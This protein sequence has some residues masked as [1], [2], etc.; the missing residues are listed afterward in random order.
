MFFSQYIVVNKGPLNKVWLAAHMQKKLTKNFV[1]EIDIVDNVKTLLDPSTPLALRLSGQLLL[2]LV[3]IYSRKARYLQEDCSS[4][5][6]NIKVVFR[7]A[8]VI[9][10]PEDAHGGASAITLMENYDDLDLEIEDI[11]LEDIEKLKAN[12]ARAS[13][14]TQESRLSQRRKSKGGE[15]DSDIEQARNA[16]SKEIDFDINIGGEG[17]ELLNFDDLDPNEPNNLD[18]SSML[19]FDAADI[20]TV[21]DQT[22]GGDE[23]NIPPENEKEDDEMDMGLPPVVDENTAQAEEPTPKAKAAEKKKRVRKRARATLDAVVEMTSKQIKQQLKDTTNIKTKREIAESIVNPKRAR[24]S[25]SQKTPFTIY[26]ADS[27]APALVNRIMGKI[28]ESVSKKARVSKEIGEEKG[29]AAGDEEDHKEDLAGPE[30]KEDEFQFEFDVGMDQSLM[31]DTT[32]D[33]GIDTS[34]EM[35]NEALDNKHGDTTQHGDPTQES[36]IEESEV[37]KADRLIKMYH[38]LKNKMADRKEI[39]FHE[40]CGPASRKAAAGIFHELLVLKTRTM[41]EVNQEEPYGDIEITKTKQFDKG[42]TPTPVE[43]N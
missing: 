13:D 43:A 41:I 17:E 16:E 6:A 28:Q 25:S 5:M 27:L 30:G 38:F 23:E 2:G 20:S 22:L 32:M 21:H 19:D 12:V 8:A 3:N 36:G 4:A 37:T 7:P 9:D 42:L 18:A 14:I 40:M 35:Q 33:G 15:S 39:T 29:G 24:T 1:I 31:N 10:L 11:T 34:L 26:L